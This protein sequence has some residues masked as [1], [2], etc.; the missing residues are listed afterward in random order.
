VEEEA[1][2]W[3]AAPG[4]APEGVAHAARTW[5]PDFAG[6]TCGP[7][8][9]L[10]HCAGWGVGGGVGPPPRLAWGREA[11]RAGPALRQVRVTWLSPC[12]W[13]PYLLSAGVGPAGGRRPV[14]LRGCARAGGGDSGLSANTCL[15]AAAAVSPHRP[16]RE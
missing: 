8:F 6:P 16:G 2:G 9:V 10:C 1:P 3:E 12:A 11:A 7:R 4:S 15:R 13:P 5:Y 14:A